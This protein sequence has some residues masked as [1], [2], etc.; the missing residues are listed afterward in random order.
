V[1]GVGLGA[2]DEPAVLIADMPLQLEDHL[3]A[4]IVE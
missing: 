2:C 1:L 3:D 4:A